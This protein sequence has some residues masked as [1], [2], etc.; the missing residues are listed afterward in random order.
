MCCKYRLCDCRAGHTWGTVLLLFFGCVFFLFFVVVVFW[1]LVFVGGGGLTSG[2]EM[3]VLSVNVPLSRRY[4]TR[5]KRSP[6]PSWTP[7]A[8]CVS[9]VGEMKERERGT[10]SCT[11]RGR[12]HRWWRGWG[13]VF[14]CVCVCLL[15]W[16]SV[17]TE[18]RRGG[19]GGVGGKAEGVKV[20]LVRE[21]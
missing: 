12:D 7:S 9:D 3:F 8:P 4:L 2:S 13:S 1:V 5:T 18:W 17:S 6:G 19:G 21:N 20:L 11:E 10:E 16:I 14:V 15:W